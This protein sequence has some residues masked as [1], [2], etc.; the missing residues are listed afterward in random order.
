MQSKS[1]LVT[2]IIALLVSVGLWFYVVT[3]ENPE[4]TATISGIPVNFTGLDVLNEDQGLIITS[5]LDTTV[6]L[7][8]TGTR[9]E[10]SKLE[11]DNI[12]I[13]VDVGRITR[14][15]DYTMNYDIDYPPEVKSSAITVD[16]NFPSHISLTVE[17]AATKTIDVRGELVGGPAEGYTTEEMTFDY[18]QIVIWGPE[19]VV[20]QV[21]HAL[22]TLE[23]SNFEKTI[24]TY[25]PYVL[26][27]KEGAPVETDEITCDVE[28]IEVTLPVVK[29][30]Q[31]PL[32]VEFIAGGG[33]TA[34]DV[35]IK[36]ISPETVTISGDPSVLDLVNQINLGNIDLGNVITNG[37]YEFKILLPN[38]VKNVSGEET[39]TVE[40]EIR[41]LETKTVR[42]STVEFAQVPEGFEASAMTQTLQVMIRASSDDI[43]QITATNV[44]AIADMSGIGANVGT[45]TVPLVIEIYG[46]PD[47][48]VIGTYNA[49][50]SL[51][52][53]VIEPPASVEGEE[54]SDQQTD[55]SD[56]EGN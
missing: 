28:E 36:D 15:Q 29:F 6:A 2:M 34:N 22:V 37:T 40:V 51:S 4:H 44:H 35:V 53:E 8:L 11:K 7:R 9:S 26:I 30:K 19:E 52:E 50:V 32:G 16:S 21:D 27:D 33:A 39:A 49:V 55:A 13:T 10:I 54:G 24:T 31:I 41:G 42:L 43:G 12:V 20:E 47:A 1:K 46:Y 25:L 48:G 45:Y 17:R 23:R 5:G 56:V 38:N 14:A 3:V 18:A